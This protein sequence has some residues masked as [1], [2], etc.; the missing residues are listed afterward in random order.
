MTHTQPQTAKEALFEQ[1]LSSNL[2]GWLSNH[3]EEP[4]KGLALRRDPGLCKIQESVHDSRPPH[5][6]ECTASA[7]DVRIGSYTSANVPHHTAR[8]ALRVLSRAASYQ[9]VP[10]RPIRLGSRAVYS[11][12]ECP[13]AVQCQ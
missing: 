13:R 12:H 6:Q 8:P 5:F 3:G 4:Q 11:L 1:V 10:R 2:N 7:R 9:Q